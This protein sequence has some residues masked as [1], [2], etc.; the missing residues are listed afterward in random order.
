MFEEQTNIV[1]VKKNWNTFKKHFLKFKTNQEKEENIFFKVLV[2]GWVGGGGVQQNS[3]V[4]NNLG[5]VESTHK[6]SCF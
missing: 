1:G 6:L 3:Y 2:G 4:F 5:L